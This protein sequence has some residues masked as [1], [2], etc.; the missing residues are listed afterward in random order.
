MAEIALKNLEAEFDRSPASCLPFDT[1]PERE[2]EKRKDSRCG[3][4]SS[5]VTIKTRVSEG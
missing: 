5:G 3:S 2:K 4:P 1:H